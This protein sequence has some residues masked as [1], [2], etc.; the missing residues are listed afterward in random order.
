[1]KSIVNLA[2]AVLV[3][4]SIQVVKAQLPNARET[5]SLVEKQT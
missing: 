3:L 4:A 1:M 5:L 2:C